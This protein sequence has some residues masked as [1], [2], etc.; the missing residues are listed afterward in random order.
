MVL[1]RPVELA[2]ISVTAELGPIVREERCG[3]WYKLSFAT[4]AIRAIPSDYG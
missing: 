4:S 3:F 1:H 2:G